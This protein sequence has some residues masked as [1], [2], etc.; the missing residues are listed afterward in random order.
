[1]VG[2]TFDRFH[3]GH[4]ALISKAFEVGKKV[5]IGISSDEFAKKL[6]KEV[7][8]TFEERFE[9]VKRFIEKKFPNRSFEMV[10]L[11]DYFGKQALSK[12]VEAI[13]VSN[14]TLHRVKIANEQRILLK[15]KPL[16]VVII[17]TVLA[18][19]GKPISSTRIRKGEIDEKGKVVRRLIKSKE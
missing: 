12:D 15:L 19:D 17:D 14:E 5:Y 13:V 2:G 7:S 6:G 4:K 18:E 10:A 16:E 1:M 9:N 3:E 8:Q 11:D